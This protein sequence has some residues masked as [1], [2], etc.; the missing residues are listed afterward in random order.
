MNGIVVGY[1]G[2]ANSQYAIEWALR[3]A[4]ATDAPVTVLAVNEVAVNP[5]TG[6]PSVIPEDDVELAHARRAAQEAAAK[7]QADI[8]APQPPAVTVTAMNGIAARELI[9]AARTAS[10]LVLGSA[11]QRDFPALRLSEISMKAT[12]YAACPVVIVPPAS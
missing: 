11:G 4:A 9:E 8:G 1:D 12:H 3:Q 10:L 6:D 2:S 7:A 5:Y